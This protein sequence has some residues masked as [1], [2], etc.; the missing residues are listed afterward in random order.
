[1]VI[2]GLLA[3]VVTYATTGYM[4]KAKRQRARS[5]IATYSGAVDAYYLDKGRF[6]TNQ[7]GLKVL[8]PE[9]VKLLQHDPWGR[10]YQFVQPG[11]GGKYDIISYGA[12]GREGGAGE[13]QDI[14]NA[15]VES[16]AK[17]K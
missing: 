14:T 17:T 2:I 13:N 4:D 9:F 8:V 16:A 10:P 5:D 1:V 11:K 15:D 12:D 3:G 7:E 6:P